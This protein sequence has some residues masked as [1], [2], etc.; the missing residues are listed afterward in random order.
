PGQ[1]PDPTATAAWGLIRA[2]QLEHPGRLMLADTGIDTGTS[3]GTGT[4]DGDGGLREALQR[5]INTGEPQVAVR[6]GRG[7]VPRLARAPLPE[8]APPPGE[9]RAWRLTVA[10]AGTVDAVVAAGCPQVLEPLAPGQVRIA[11]SAAG[12]NFRDV[13]ISLGMVPGTGGLGGEGAGIVLE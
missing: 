1:P 9:E 3:S 5:G 2:A 13:L 4:S 12:V 6:D 8:L 7:L 11:V 10:A